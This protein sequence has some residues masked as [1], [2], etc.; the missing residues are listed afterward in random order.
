MTEPNTPEPDSNLPTAATRRRGRWSLSIVWLIPLV[1]IVVGGWLAVRNIMNQG[2]TISIQFRTA[3]GLQA[4]ETRIKFRDVDVGVIK[5][6]RLAEDGPGVTVTAELN[7][8]VEPM[9]VDDTKFWVVKPRIAGSGVSGLTTL[10][11][12]A[13][14]GMEAGKSEQARNDFTGLEVPPVLTEGLPGR[15]FVLKSDDLGSIDYGSPV[16]DR[17]IAV[18]EVVAYRLNP[19]GSGVSIEIF[20]RAPYDKYVTE[21][22]RF[23]EASGIDFSMDATGVKVNTQSLASV[24][25]GGIA[26]APLEGEDAGKEA[27]SMAAFRLYD[28]RNSAFK[29]YDNRVEYFELLFRESV[30]GLTVGAPV[31]F[32]GIPIGEVTDIGLDYDR[33]ARRLNIPVTVRLYPERLTS[34]LRRDVGRLTAERQH[35][36]VRMI[37]S[38]LRGQLRMGSLITGQLYVALDFFPNA[39]K[40]KLDTTQSPVQIPTVQ[41]DLQELQTSLSSIARKLDQIP[42]QDIV[43]DLRRAINSLNDVLKSADSTLHN[44]NN[45]MLPAIKGTVED[46]RKTLDHANGLLS[47]DSPTQTELR[48]TLREVSRSAASLRTLTDYLDRHPEALIRGRQPE[49]KP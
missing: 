19:D 46:A 25:L 28:D 41:G 5:S 33:E 15:T 40:T 26:F 13:Y 8:Q 17:R 3:E 38:G 45:D 16:Y 18:G 12:G 34:R 32:R 6:I 27:E 24:V 21:S 39:A 49:D 31:E 22:A 20:V 36:F 14:I 4:E 47:Q 10:L 9:L 1:A 48:D 23:W 11:S 37:D 44:V 42:F 7:K 29:R 35:E 43:N 30:H 2:P